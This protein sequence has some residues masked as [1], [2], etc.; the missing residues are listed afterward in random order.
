M[1]SPIVERLYIELDGTIRFRVDG[2]E[3]YDFEPGP[4]KA[5]EGVRVDLTKPKQAPYKIYVR[6]FSC[7]VSLP[8]CLL[9]LDLLLPWFLRSS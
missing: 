4:P 8:S 3:F 9:F 5:T 2:D 1:D 7:P 6:P